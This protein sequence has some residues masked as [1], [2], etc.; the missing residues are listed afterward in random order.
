MSRAAMSMVRRIAQAALRRWLDA[1]DAV[2]QWHGRRRRL[3]HL[4]RVFG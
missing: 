3:R 4:E 2:A 1:R